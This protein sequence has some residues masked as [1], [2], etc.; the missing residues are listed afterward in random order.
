ML[1]LL[2]LSGGL[3]ALIAWQLDRA[4]LEEQRALFAAREDCSCVLWDTL[5]GEAADELRGHESRVS[6]VEVPPDGAA[7]ATASWDATL[8][9]W[10]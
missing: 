6:S 2:V 8:K 7:V 3:T 4:G 5:R 1:E 9:V 10:N